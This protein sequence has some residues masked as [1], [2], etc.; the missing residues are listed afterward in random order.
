MSVDRLREA[1]DRLDVEPTESPL[2]DDVFAATAALLRAHADLLDNFGAGWE[3]RIA[4]TME[5][6]EN[7]AEF[8]LG[9]Q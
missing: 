5:R 7:L 1:A 9:D 2:V 8:I 3:A 6:A 4:K